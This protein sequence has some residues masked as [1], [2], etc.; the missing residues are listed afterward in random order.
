V[1]GPSSTLIDG[2]FA[3]ISLGHSSG[4]PAELLGLLVL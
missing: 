4:S 3:P 1:S 2:T